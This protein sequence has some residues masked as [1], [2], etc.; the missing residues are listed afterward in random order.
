MLNVSL[1]SFYHRLEEY[2]SRYSLAA[3]RLA[4]HNLA[5]PDVRIRILPV[6]MD[7]SPEV[8]T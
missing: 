8:T 3:F 2:P 4:A 1:V 5:I 6:H 7:E